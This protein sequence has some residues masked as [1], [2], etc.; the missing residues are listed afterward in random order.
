MEKRIN[1]KIEQYVGTFKTD[2]RNKI[3]EL[4]F[5]QSEKINELI[6]YVY[7]YQ[8][9]SILKDDLTKRKRVK[10]SI[11][12]L[13][14]CNARRANN[15]QCT[16]RRKE[17]SEYC[18]THMK[19]TPN[20]Y[21]NLNECSD[22]NKVNCGDCKCIC[23]YCNICNAEFEDKKNNERTIKISNVYVNYEI[24]FVIKCDLCLI[25]VHTTCHLKEAK[26]FRY[27][28]CPGCMI[29]AC[30]DCSINI[31]NHCKKCSNNFITRIIGDRRYFLSNGN[32]CN[33]CY[34]QNESCCK[35]H[36]DQDE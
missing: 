35:L 18:G 6:E 4:G 26:C 31:S 2:V 20:G 11:P 17:G 14:R 8:R 28:Q 36:L 24:P 25:H 32:F 15:E 16:R 19:G 30:Q 3:V 29:R 23:R 33:N 22:C 1:T 21:L 12:S 34:V 10:N 5:D 7:E 9:L 27:R 13:N